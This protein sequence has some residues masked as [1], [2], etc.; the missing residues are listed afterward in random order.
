MSKSQ[1]QLNVAMAQIGP[2]CHSLY[3]SLVYINAEGEIAEERL[4]WSPGDGHGLRVHPLGRE[5]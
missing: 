4:T 1:D 3:C 2:V 5:S